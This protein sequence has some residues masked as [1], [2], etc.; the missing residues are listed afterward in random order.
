MYEHFYKTLDL[1]SAHHRAGLAAL[2]LFGKWAQN[3]EGEFS[4]TVE[5]EGLIVRFDQEGLRGLLRKVY[6]GVLVEVLS[7]TAFEGRAPLR[8][9]ERDGKT[10]QVYT[11][12]VPQG[13]FLGEVDPTPTKAWL[14]LWR[15][16]IF[17]SVRTVKGAR[18]P[19]ERTERG[20]DPF[21]IEKLYQG[22][23]RKPHDPVL[24]SGSWMIGAREKTSDGTAIRE[25]AYLHFLL[26]F[27]PFVAQPFLRRAFS[28]HH[29]TKTEGLYVG[30]PDVALLPQFCQTFPKQMR[31][32]G[33]KLWGVFPEE[34]SANC[35]EEL[36]L[37][38]LGGPSE[39]IFGMDVFLCEKAGQSMHVRGISR[40]G[41]PGK[42]SPVR[43]LAE[44]RNLFWHPWF[45]KAFLENLL[46]KRPWWH[47][48]RPFPLSL[49][50]ESSWRHDCRVAFARDPQSLA[51]M[52]RQTIDQ[53]IRRRLA[54][55]LRGKDTNSTDTWKRLVRM[56]FAEA[57]RLKPS[58][59]LAEIMPCVPQEGRS[60]FDPRRAREIQV[61]SLLALCVL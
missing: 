35:P 11:A 1:P 59:F 26:H 42:H 30:V 22:L 40:V 9:E 14:K 17:Q 27:W 33:Q 12:V 18:L 50:E 56:T 61:L 19:Y 3:E 15:D 31:Q 2:H 47:G 44:L 28:P 34:A 39:T 58:R 32:R 45:R 7:K 36:I 57:T 37:P 23:I 60:L 20:E 8:E 25:P 29:G 53:Y 4:T 55:T 21:D 52:V 46:A 6:K 51:E 10:F 54:A 5:D 38:F 43:Q 16:M 49:M 48:F 24:M 41:I 13:A